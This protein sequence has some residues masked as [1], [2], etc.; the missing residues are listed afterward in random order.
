MFTREQILELIPHRPP[1][2]LVDELTDLQPGI[3]AIG[4][5]YV[6]PD[7]YYFQGHFP[8]NPVMPGVL[9]V[10]GLAQ[11]GSTILLC[12]DEYRGMTPM[13]A[14]LDSVRFKKVVKPG[15][16][17][18][19]E[20]TLTKLKGKMGKMLGVAKVDGKVAVSGEFIFALV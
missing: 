6:H 11:T 7:E 1:F 20:T 4:K 10:E 5:K 15:D 18:V 14:G 8:G 16:E 19:Y 9:I 13:F 3:S 12:M 17:I 2:L